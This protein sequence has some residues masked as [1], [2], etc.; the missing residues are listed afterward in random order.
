MVYLCIQH[1]LRLMLSGSPLLYF[2]SYLLSLP[3][4]LP[5]PLCPSL[6]VVATILAS[7]GVQ[8]VSLVLL[9]G[10][11]EIGMRLP[12]SNDFIRE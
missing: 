1:G 5:L 9:I 2:F 3:V 8:K 12:D 10:R 4:Y 7:A 6:P 11:S